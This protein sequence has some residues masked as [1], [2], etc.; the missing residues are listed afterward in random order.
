MSVF[1]FN[2]SSNLVTIFI[3]LVINTFLFVSLGL[4]SGDL[5]YSFKCVFFLV[6]F[7]YGLLLFIGTLA[8]EK[9][10]ITPRFFNLQLYRENFFHLAWL[11][12]LEATQI[13]SEDTYSLCFKR[14]ANSS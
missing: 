10:G 3:F 2:S 4:V 5:I 12:I 8:F 1:S 13:F 14:F 6:F 7:L 9:S 11:V